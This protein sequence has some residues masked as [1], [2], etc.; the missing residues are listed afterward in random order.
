MIS[1]RSRLLSMLGA[2]VV[3]A[4]CSQGSRQL[5]PSGPSAVLADA[6]ASLGAA[7]GAWTTSSRASLSGP[8]FEVREESQGRGQ[9]GLGL[10]GIRERV[11]QLMGTI[12]L[13]SSPGNG[14]KLTIE[15]PAPGPAP[16]TNAVTT[17]ALGTASVN[18]AILHG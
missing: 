16:S 15:L 13:D 18:G 6:G 11:S 7:S 14:T 5:S 10:I 12:H 9:S 1:S 4:A 17:P 8:G 3:A 2:V